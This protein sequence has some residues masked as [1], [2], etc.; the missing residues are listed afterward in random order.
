MK[1]QERNFS[2]SSWKYFKDLK[3]NELILT[4]NPKTKQEEWQKAK[5]I[6]SY[7]YNGKLY[8]ITLK[9]GDKLVVSPEHKIYSLLSNTITPSFDNKN[10]LP[11][12]SP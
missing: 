6:F 11:L 9:N 5:E 3:G 2:K 4:L 8:E 12:N 10:A 7:D 1:Q